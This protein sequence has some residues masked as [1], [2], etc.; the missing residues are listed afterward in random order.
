MRKIGQILALEQQMVGCI[1]SAFS[2][3]FFWKT[4]NFSVKWGHTIKAQ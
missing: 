3:S 1:S 2:F 4:F